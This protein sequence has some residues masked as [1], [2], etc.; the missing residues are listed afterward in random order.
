[1]HYVGMDCHIRILAFLKTVLPHTARYTRLY[2][3]PT[4]FNGCKTRHMAG[5]LS[6]RQQV[7]SFHRVRIRTMWNF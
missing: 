3:H 6:V 7:L 4:G 1:M 5:L 2:D